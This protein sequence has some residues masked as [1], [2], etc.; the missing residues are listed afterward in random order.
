M[1]K[2]H[3]QREPRPRAQPFVF[4]GA[5]ATAALGAPQW[6]KL[7][8]A[9]F[10]RHAGV[11][12]A[13]KDLRSSFVTFLLSAEN[14]DEQ[15]KKAVALAMRHSAEQQAGPALLLGQKSPRAQSK[16][17]H[18]CKKVKFLNGATGPHER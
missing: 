7:V 5:D 10:K 12:L 8:K 13:P 14:T 11:P 17:V 2:Q 4:T 16:S 15:L 1:H 6:T 18:G 9:V 3:K